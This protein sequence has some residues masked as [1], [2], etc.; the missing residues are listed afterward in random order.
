M[1]KGFAW[2]QTNIAAEMA[3]MP[4]RLAATKCSAAGACVL[5]AKKPRGRQRAAESSSWST[6]LSVAQSMAATAVAAPISWAPSAYWDGNDGAWNSFL[7]QVG[8]PAQTFRVL[9]STTGQE[10]WVPVP[11]GC[12]A[13]SPDDP[14]YCGFLRGT[15]A[16]DG[17]NSSGFAT[18][19][20]STW[21]VMGVYTLDAQELDLGYGGNGLYG[22]DT[23]AWGNASTS[24]NLTQQIVAGIADTDW[25]VGL[26]G[27][28]P[29]ASNFTNFNNPIPSYLSNLVDQNTIPSLSWG[30]TAGASYRDQAQAS[31][32]LGG[33]DT[34]RF[35][36]PGISIKMN[37]DNSRPLQVAVT[38]ILAENTLDSTQN[39][40]PTATFHFVDSTV[41]HVWL[42]DDS[43][44]A[45]VAAFGLTY[46]NTTDL[47]LVNDTMHEKLLELNPTITFVLGDSTTTTVDGTQ[48]IV[49]PYAAFD[50]QASYPFY[51]NSTN[52]FPIR[53]AANDT[54]YTIG[55]TLLQE[56]YLIAD[57]GRNNFTIAQA[58]FDNMDAQSLV[59]ISKPPASNM[60][61]E[62]QISKSSSGLSGGSIGGIVVGAVAAIAL[63]AFLIWF[64]I[65]CKK[66][67]RLELKSSEEEAALQDYP[68]DNKSIPPTGTELGSDAAVHEVPSNHTLG[69]EADGR[70]LRSEVHGD[71]AKRGR[72]GM[73][74]L[75]TPPPLWSSWSAQEL[76]TQPIGHES[77]LLAEAPGSEGL[78]HELAADSVRP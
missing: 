25:W 77:G 21:N 20:S 49:L 43:I 36:G 26:V 4:S 30:Y 42:P 23:V 72:T 61:G 73:Q 31:L 19:E 47:F 41:P 40:L 66:R 6:S 37:A 46:D 32:T 58:S 24:P 29:K 27:I 14:G 13:A 2:M 70:Q 16:V 44:E 65:F 55:R 76:H 35:E 74:E 8:T 39:L 34:D 78:R 5:V 68:G 67:R 28:G 63:I 60:T 15:L 56:A 69:H 75:P 59:E 22:R 45:F 10:L 57:H 12:T 53:R 18:N 17:T 52:Y 38:K 9:P 71:T 11:D 48:N 62:E 50:L 1:S 7:V 54:Q 3:E 33:Y 51:P 64:F